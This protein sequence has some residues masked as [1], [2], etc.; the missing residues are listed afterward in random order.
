MYHIA[1]YFSCFIETE[2]LFKVAGNAVT[3]TV[4]VVISREW[5]EIE[6]LLLQTTNRKSFM[7]HGIV[8]ILM[9]FSDLE[10]RAP[11]S[12]LA[13]TLKVMHLA[14]TLK[15]VH[16]AVTLEVMHLAVTLKVVHLAMTL[17]VVHLAVTLE[18][19]HHVPCTPFTM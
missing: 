9:T 6:M 19:M 13:V 10:G 14:V 5:C 7:T 4:E 16:L 11:C 12:D 3:Y 1:L 2:G 15:V 8:A 18:V 17:K